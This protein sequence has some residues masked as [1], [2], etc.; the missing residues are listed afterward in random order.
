MPGS[1]DLDNQLK[2][3]TRMSPREAQF[4]LNEM[5]YMLTVDEEIHNEWK[6]LYDQKPVKANRE[7]NNQQIDRDG[8]ENFL[9][10]AHYFE[11]RKPRSFEEENRKH[12]TDVDPVKYSDKATWA[13][14]HA[15]NIKDPLALIVSFLSF[16]RRRRIKCLV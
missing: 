5:T 11:E 9:D 1:N 10:Y 3:K 8:N 7:F 12:H 2:K 16:L 4:L 15:N 13:G 14:H 6:T